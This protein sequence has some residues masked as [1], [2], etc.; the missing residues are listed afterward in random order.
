[1]CVF[2]YQQAVK[3]DVNEDPQAADDQVEQVVQELHIH[4]H[5]QVAPCE[6]SPVPHEARQEDYL[7][8]QLQNN[9]EGMF[10]IDN[11]SGCG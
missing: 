10:F 4:D 6:G 8:T 7:V 5:G 9:G 11:K 2:M 1:M 3:E